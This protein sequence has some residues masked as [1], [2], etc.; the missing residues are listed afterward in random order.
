MVIERDTER[1]S[2]AAILSPRT[3]S[4]EPPFSKS[5]SLATGGQ[6]GLPWG[7]SDHPAVKAARRATTPRCSSDAAMPSHASC[8][9]INRFVFIIS[10]SNM[11]GDIR[12]EPRFHLGCFNL[13]HAMYKLF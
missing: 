7:A 1:D 4:Y 10:Y 12:M 13:I 5:L 9:R 6:L 2:D 3:D 11:H 8:R